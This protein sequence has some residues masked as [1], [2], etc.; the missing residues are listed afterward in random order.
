MVVT[1]ATCNKVI[2]GQVINAL[3][4]YYHPTCF[5]CAKCKKP[6]T[7]TTFQIVDSK[8]YCRQDY[9]ELFAPK[10]HACNKPITGRIINALDH[11]WHEEHFVCSMCKAKL[12]GQSF[13]ERDGKPLCQ[14]CYEENIADK[15]KACGKP[16]VGKI[17]VALEAKWHAECFKCIQCGK[18]IVDE[19]FQARDGNPLCAKC[20]SA[21]QK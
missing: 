5:I 21:G 13:M 11:T 10:C 4:K 14:K 18:Q 6:I 8:P 3:D 19:M 2:E 15:C 7:G 1:C 12:V 16:V 9:D 20:A 17:I